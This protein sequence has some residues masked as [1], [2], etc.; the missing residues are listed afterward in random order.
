MFNIII[1]IHCF[2]YQLIKIDE[3]FK[4]LRTIVM[5]LETE[6]NELRAEVVKLLL[7]Q[8]SRLNIGKNLIYNMLCV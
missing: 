7:A 6:T 2:R 1:L 3:G 8:E 5:K 4:E